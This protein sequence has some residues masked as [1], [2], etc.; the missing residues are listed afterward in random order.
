MKRGFLAVLMV[1]GLVM[2]ASAAT[3]K[4]CI[5]A[6][7]DGNHVFSL[8]YD[9]RPVAKGETF[10]KLRK[11]D[12]ETTENF[13]AHERFGKLGH[14]DTKKDIT[15]GDLKV[16]AGEYD[17]G[18]NADTDGKFYFVVWMGGEAKKTKVEL[19]KHQDAPVSHLG[20]LLG[21]GEGGSFLV[22]LYG[23]Y[24][25][26]IPVSGLGKA[27]Y[28]V[29]SQTDG[30]EDFHLSYDA[31]RVSE[32]ENYSAWKQGDMSKDDVASFNSNS[33]FGKLGSLETKGE[34]TIGEIKIPAGKYDW[35]FN[36]DEKANIS[37]AVWVGGEAKKTKLELTKHKE[38]KVPHLAIMMGPDENVS[39]LMGLYSDFYTLI[40]VSVASAGG[41]DAKEAKAGK[42]EGKAEEA[43][44]D[45][46]SWENLNTKSF[47][48]K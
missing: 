27:K 38:A 11:G 40:P 7:V 25:S 36:A 8:V 6:E 21:P 3:T 22:A 44:A 13:N 12:K 1:A 42:E 41:G 37:F 16:P 2:T 17:C 46:D 34:T 14:L 5:G 26:L 30:N 45:D 32:G 47:S 19:T 10:E 18:F 24:F 23:N 33:H 4:Y 20:M 43:A 9:A 31:K 29:G 28:C 15:I 48:G 39:H 35:G